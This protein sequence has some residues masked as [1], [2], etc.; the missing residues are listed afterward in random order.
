MSAK[1]VVLAQRN[2]NGVDVVLPRTSADLTGYE[3]ADAPGVETVAE[4]LDDIYARS[5]GNIAAL[6]GRV[7][8]LETGQVEQ[9]EDIAALESGVADW[10]ASKPGIVQ[11]VEA[12]EAEPDPTPESIGAAKAKHA[13][14]HATGGSDAVTPDSIGAAQKI[15][16]HTFADISGTLS[17]SQG[18]T[19]VN[20]LQALAAQL[21]GTGVFGGVARL[22]GE[23]YFHPDPLDI[24]ISGLT[25]GHLLLWIALGYQKNNSSS[26]GPL[27]QMALGQIPGS[28][29]NGNNP[30][31]TGLLTGLTGANKYTKDSV[32]FSVVG[33]ALSSSTELSNVRNMDMAII[34]EPTVN[35]RAYRIQQAWPMYI[36]FYEL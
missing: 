23:F 13:A 8:V 22:V 3:N 31:S 17:P 36:Q 30:P 21:K 6:A 2:G 4:A 16:T 33:M 29:D 7:D 26:N 9:N 12:L 24:S 28:R 15:H 34:L 32:V 5:P 1:N 27:P 25:P 35:V 11:R 14:Q 18:G 20:S 10:T 19:G